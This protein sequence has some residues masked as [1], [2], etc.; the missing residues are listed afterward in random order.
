MWAQ[1]VPSKL[2]SYQ[3]LIPKCGCPQGK[4]LKELRYRR[5][6]RPICR[7]RLIS[8]SWQ[9]HLFCG[10]TR[11]CKLSHSQLEKFPK[12]GYKQPLNMLFCLTRIFSPLPL[13]NFA[14]LILG[15]IF[16]WFTLI[17]IVCWS[18]Y[19]LCIAG[20]HSNCWMS[21]LYTLLTVLNAIPAFSNYYKKLSFSISAS[22]YTP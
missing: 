5:P 1:G 2:N 6:C 21:T 7:R 8:V 12:L 13:P 18:S 19:W 11:W 4:H 14:W 20:I 16:S 17:P 15:L 22:K 10:R 9:H 3:H